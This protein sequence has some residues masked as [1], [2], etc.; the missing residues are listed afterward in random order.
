MRIKVKNQHLKYRDF[1][2]FQEWCLENNL[3][4]SKKKS[5]DLFMLTERYDIH[6]FAM[7]EIEENEQEYF[8]GYTAYTDNDYEAVFQCNYYEFL[9]MFSELDNEQ[10]EIYKW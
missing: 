4:P 3:T 1:V 2:K 7:N 10:K 9:E 6:E 5:L 8:Y